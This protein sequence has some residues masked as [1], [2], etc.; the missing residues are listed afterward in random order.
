MVVWRIVLAWKNDH[1]FEASICV[2]QGVGLRALAAHL[3]DRQQGRQD[4]DQQGDLLVAA[5]D[6]AVSA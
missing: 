4:G 5:F 2:G 3:R 1:R 6:M